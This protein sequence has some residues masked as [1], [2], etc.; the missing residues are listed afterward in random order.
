[1]DRL[2]DLIDELR[3]VGVDLK[4]FQK[5]LVD[6]PALYEDRE[7]QLCWKKGED[8]IEY[9][10]EADAGYAGRQATEL[11]EPGAGG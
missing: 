11:R 7:V 10:H 8:Q 1:M 2:S 9:W 5:G 3:E 4:D 6:F